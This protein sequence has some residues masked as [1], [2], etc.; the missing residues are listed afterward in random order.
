MPARALGFA[1]GLTIPGNVDLT[2]FVGDMVSNITAANSAISGLQAN[3]TAA[4]VGMKT[5]VDTQVASAIISASGYGNSVV[6]AYLPVNPTITSIQANA[7]SASANVTAAN[8]S[9]TGLRANITAANL[10]IS[11]TLSNVTA[12]NS[13]ITA[14][15][16]NI[17]AANANIVSLQGNTTYMT[18]N[19]GGSVFTNNVYLGQGN[20]IVGNINAAGNLVMRGTDATTIR[21]VRSVDT[22]VFTGEIYGNIDFAGEDSSS[23]PGGSAA[24]VRARMSVQSI[25]S[26]GQAAMKFYT[27]D[28]DQFGGGYTVAPT[29]VT[30]S[31]G[32]YGYTAG[33]EVQQV[34]EFETSAQIPPQFAPVANDGSSGSPYLFDITSGAVTKFY[35]GNSSGGGGMAEFDI[36][37]TFTYWYAGF[38]GRDTANILLSG[39][40][41]STAGYPVVYYD[42]GQTDLEISVN[43]I[44]LVDSTASPRT[45]KRL[46]KQ[47]V[48]TVVCSETFIY[49]VLD[50]QLQ[51]PVY[52][53]DATN[54]A[55]GAVG[56]GKAFLQANATPTVTGLYLR[57]DAP[58]SAGVNSKTNWQW[59]VKFRSQSIS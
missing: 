32:Y 38:A 53:S 47:W 13:A 51:S 23:G 10:N 34:P 9:I 58:T 3:V 54:W 20:L 14:L 30:N 39:Y 24:G 42:S 59:T 57:L 27:G 2:Q 40:L 21:F 46:R 22:D 43:G 11:S 28:G 12:A 48:A 15:R 35:G 18:S 19:V 6:A 50:Q 44:H 49:T 4:N 25:G 52:N 37:G 41:S 1:S 56:A 45:Y 31:S 7:S 33:F 5:Y 29:L 55:A 16:A 17:T 36:G 26:Y 8:T